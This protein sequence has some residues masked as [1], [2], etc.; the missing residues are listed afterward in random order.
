MVLEAVLVG[1]ATLF[2]LYFMGGNAAGHITGPLVGCRVLKFKKAVIFSAVSVFIGALLQGHVIRAV[3]GKG[4]VSNLQVDSLGVTIV[5]LSAAV[6]VCLATIFG[7]P[8]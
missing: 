2:L 7:W 5:L 1:A 8:V 6:W 3:V 4:I